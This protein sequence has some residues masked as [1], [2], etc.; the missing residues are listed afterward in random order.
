V[1]ELPFLQITLEELAYL[2]G[3]AETIEDRRRVDELFRAT[4]TEIDAADAL[5][6]EISRD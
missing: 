4:S 6:S 3:L 1:N 5:A 2:A